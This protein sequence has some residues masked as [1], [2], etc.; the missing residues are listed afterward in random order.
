MSEP[1]HKIRP[2][3]SDPNREPNKLRLGSQSSNPNLHPSNSPHLR[4][5][6][7]S[8][9]ENDAHEGFLRLIEKN[10]RKGGNMPSI[11]MSTAAIMPSPAMLWI[12][13]GNVNYAKIFD[14]D[15]NHL[16]HREIWKCATWP[17][18]VSPT[19]SLQMSTLSSAN[20]KSQFEQLNQNLGDGDGSRA[21]DMGDSEEEQLFS[22][23]GVRE[24]PR[25]R[26]VHQGAQ[27]PPQSPPPKPKPF[28]L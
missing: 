17:P 18:K 27:Q 21:T 7:T 6:G 11:P 1:S 12:F 14:L 23:E 3:S 8:E 2:V 22:C 20:P 19:I 16:I 10:N 26:S 9:L 15:Q 13:K 5:S 28:S 25:R 24:E 4:K